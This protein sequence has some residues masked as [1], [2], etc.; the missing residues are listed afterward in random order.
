MRDFRAA[1]SNVELSF[2]TG[3]ND[4]VVVSGLELHPEPASHSTI[5]SLSLNA[6]GFGAGMQT[7]PDLG[8]PA[9]VI[10]GGRE[11]TLQKKV[12]RG[13]KFIGRDGRAGMD[14]RLQILDQAFCLLSVLF[15]R[16][17]SED[18]NAGANRDNCAFRGT[19]KPVLLEVR[20]G[21]SARGLAQSKRLARLRRLF[22]SS[23]R[24]WT[25]PVLWRFDRL[26]A[27]FDDKVIQSTV[28][29]FE[30]MGD[31]F[32]N[33]DDISFGQMA[34]VASGDFFSARF[35]G[36]G[37]ADFD[38]LPTGDECGRTFE[39]VKNI[40]ILVVDLDFAGARSVSGLDFE[41]VGCEQR[42][43]PGKRSGYFF[44]GE[45]DDG[46]FGCGWV[47]GGKDV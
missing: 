13:R 3:G 44:V 2:I 30:P 36:G 8:E 47:I 31:A 18:L 41:V 12:A 23:A 10:A 35:A 5:V 14:P 27:D 43:A 37:C 39:D 28:H 24:S 15:R 21:K 40:G 34:L 17:V 6:R 20:A 45:V 1:T 22:R 26:L 11:I 25:A 7:I 4:D 38:G 32:R 46:G 42:A 19:V 9:E 29:F 16:H 33:D